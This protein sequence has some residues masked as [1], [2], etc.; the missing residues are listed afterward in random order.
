M[1]D[2]KQVCTSS[3]Q[4]KVPAASPWLYTRGR[5]NM[6]LE[7]YFPISLSNLVLDVVIQL[8]NHSLLPV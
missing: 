2:T 3:V 8:L 5:Q 6:T 1:N 7:P 4:E